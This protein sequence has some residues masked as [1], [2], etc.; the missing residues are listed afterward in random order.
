MK[1]G[2]MADKNPSPSAESLIGYLTA[3]AKT[4]IL[5]IGDI[6][7]DRFVRGDVGRISSEGPIPVMVTRQEHRMLGQAGNTFAN[8]C[9]LGVQAA[10]L[11]IIGKDREG[12][13]ISALIAS[14]GTSTDGLI[15]NEQTPTTVK[16]RYMSG[17]QQVFRV[18][19]E[20]AGGCNPQFESVLLRKI[21]EMVPQQNAVI[22]SDYG[23][24][25]L[26][27]AIIRRT[28]EIANINNIPVLVDPRGSDLSK[29]RGATVATPNRKELGE[30][31][32]GMPTTTDQNIV[33][34]AYHLMEQSGIKSIVATRSAD[35]MSI[36]NAQ[37]PPLHLR[38][39][40]KEVFD[41]SGAGDTVI[42]TIAAGLAAG[43]PLTAAASLAN[44]AGGIVVGKVGTA[45]IRT[46]EIVDVLMHSDIASSTP[47]ADR[48]HTSRIV[49]WDSALEHIERWQARGHKIGFTNGCFDI[50]HAGHVNYLNAAR[51]ECDRLILAINTDSSVRLLKGPTRPINNQESRA[52]VM[53]GLAA[54][55]LVVFFGAEKEGDDNT[56]RAVIEHLKPDIYFKGGDYTIE[57]LP[58]APIVHAYG[59]KIRLMTVT[60]GQSTTGIIAKIG[61]KE[62]GKA[63]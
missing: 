27:N 31:T 33:D 46:Q 29:Y 37:S 62:A 9:G 60:E 3:M 61:H 53:A 41:V 28:I 55:D 21:E 45:I 39:V 54:I 17:H 20:G 23:Y 14:A 1:V 58:E 16:T 40:A 38:T 4:R 18:D 8:L 10:I 19:T 24:G 2:I 6:C 59:G 42:A 5:V 51:A 32:G 7:L 36:I 44:I 26:S 50:L 57:S 49:D 56:A 48:G 12:E 52:T 11:S 22:L 30:A 43:A 63:A 15:V 13:I 25:L 34:A 35:G 47:I